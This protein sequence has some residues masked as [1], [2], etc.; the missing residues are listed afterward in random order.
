MK[1]VM[2]LMCGMPCVVYAGDWWCNYYSPG[3][4]ADYSGGTIT[5]PGLIAGTYDF[6]ENCS[7]KKYGC[8]E[9][10]DEDAGDKNGKYVAIIGCK[11]CS[12]GYEL[13]VLSSSE[14]ADLTS[15]CQAL[16]FEVCKEEENVSDLEQT[17]CVDS[18]WE[19]YS[20]VYQRN[21]KRAWNGSTCINVQA[22]YRCNAGY[23]GI[24]GMSSS[25]SGCTMCPDATGVYTNTDLIE[26]ASVLNGH[27]Y[28]RP[29]NNATV[30]ECW[31]KADSYY[32]LSGRYNYEGMCYQDGTVG[33]DCS[34]VSGVCTTSSGTV[35]TIVNGVKTNV[36]G[37]TYCWCNVGT[38][39]FYL[40]NQSSYC[41]N[42]CPNACSS[43]VNN[44]TNGVATNLGCQ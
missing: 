9:I 42:G 30:G 21:Y 3:Y 31:L 12:S 28:S 15:E 40:A 23:Y 16:S 41:S 5:C 11:T 44:D 32:D 25:A 8:F 29:G 4:Q 18:G 13:S 35:A 2:F 38:K 37:G 24:D 26:V 36:S 34:A 43:W 22:V 27:I 7:T 6:G 19:D 20:L 17:E 39:S 10:D 14:S 1:K 33:V